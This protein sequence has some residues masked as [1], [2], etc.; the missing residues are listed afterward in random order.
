MGYE[1]LL[2]ST[3]VRL[4]R[5]FFHPLFRAGNQR[6]NF[7]RP[8][9]CTLECS[10]DDDS[11]LVNNPEFDTTWLRDVTGLLRVH[12]FPGTPVST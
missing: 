10:H 9:T 1:R 6:S 4:R 11:L 8:K 5:R 7:Q 12:R 2:S 3:Q